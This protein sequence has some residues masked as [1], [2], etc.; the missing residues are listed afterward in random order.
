MFPVY[1]FG[2]YTPADSVR[3]A[4]GD[5]RH[6]EFGDSAILFQLKFNAAVDEV[7]DSLATRDTLNYYTLTAVLNDSLK[8]VQG[9]APN[10]TI[11]VNYHEN[12]HEALQLTGNTTI[13]IDMSD[14][15]Q[16]ADMVSGRATFTFSVFNTNGT[17]T[18]NIITSDDSELIW[19]W[20]GVDSMSLVA[21]RVT[22]YIGWVSQLY[23]KVTVDAYTIVDLGS[24]ILQ[25]GE[26]GT[27]SNDTTV[28]TFDEVVYITD[29]TGLRASINDTII[30]VDTVLNSGNT[31]LKLVLADTVIGTDTVKFSAL[32]TNNI[33]DASDNYLN[34]LSDSSIT[35]YTGT[36][37]LS[38]VIYDYDSRQ[39]VTQGTPPD[40]NSWVDQENSVS[41]SQSTDSKKP[42][43]GTV[44]DNGIASLDFDQASSQTLESA[45]IQ[46]NSGSDLTDL[47]V[48]IVGKFP[49]DLLQTMFS[50]QNSVSVYW[51]DNGQNFRIDLFDSSTGWY[52]FEWAA[53]TADELAVYTLI[54]DI[55][56]DVTFTKNNVT[57][58]TP[59]DLSALVGIDDP[60]SVLYIGSNI[61]LNQYN[62]GQIQRIIIAETSNDTE[63]TN[64]IEG[65]MTDYGITP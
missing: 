4:S 38:N 23:T 27:L 49:T 61:D 40:I 42:H 18:I 52:I 26:I 39:G 25:S 20:N 29:T 36:V 45:S 31:T 58:G 11:S 47:C 32:A 64:Y 1:M 24:P 50:K 48:I 3:D 7:N 6:L 57:V 14:L 60:S 8:S 17:D 44:S 22:T 9:L 37:V 54:V 5:I 13:V 2:Q 30:T 63:I 12:H 16:N 51:K 41:V 19:D 28:L 35:N 59:E 55:P 15:Y 33:R 21:N 10:D 56:N 65:L 46:M 62:E 43:L 53:Q 34:A